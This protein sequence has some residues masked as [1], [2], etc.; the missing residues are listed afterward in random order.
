MAL[1]LA[2][3]ELEL[4]EIPYIKN[5]LHANYSY[6]SISIGSKQGWLISA[7]LKVPETFEPDMIFIEISDP[8]GFINI[9]DVYL[10][11]WTE[12]LTKLLRNCGER[13]SN[14]LMFCSPDMCHEI[15]LS[16]R[17]EHHD[18]KERTP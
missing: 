14:S 5:S 13:T 7:K 16:F 3:R 11:I 8:E 2:R 12:S 1:D 6:K 10:V 4:R 15:S 9:P 18:F 17:K